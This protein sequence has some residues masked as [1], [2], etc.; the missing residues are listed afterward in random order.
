MSTWDDDETEFGELDAGV[1]ISALSVEVPLAAVPAA[2]VDR[3]RGDPPRP[4]TCAR[5]AHMDG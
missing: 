5:A 4:R 2:R 1:V 3:R